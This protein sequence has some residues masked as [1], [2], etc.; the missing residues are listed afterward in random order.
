VTKKQAEQFAA[1]AD[2]TALGDAWGDSPLW[3]VSFPGL[4]LLLDVH[5]GSEQEA[6]QQ[7][8]AAIEERDA[9]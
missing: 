2:A 8:A 9:P 5:A 3:R 6:R 4:S 7:A 1:A